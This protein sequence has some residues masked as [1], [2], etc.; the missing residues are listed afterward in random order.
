MRKAGLTYQASTISVYSLS[1]I[2]HALITVDRSAIAFSADCAV[3]LLKRN[4]FVDKRSTIEGQHP[5][6]CRVYMLD[7][8]HRFGDWVGSIQVLV[9]QS[10]RTS[11]AAPTGQ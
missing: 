6:A 11:I 2:T 7:L 1:C 5:H 8:T 9:C 4:I 3:R 10:S